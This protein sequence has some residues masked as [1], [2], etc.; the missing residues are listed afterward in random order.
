[1]LRASSLCRM[2]HNLYPRH[3]R[4]EEVDAHLYI[5]ESS[6][7]DIARTASLGQQEQPL[8]RQ[9]YLPHTI[10]GFN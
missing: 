9:S 10:V 3:A 4:G 8:L 6:N 7:W 5:P 2:G 1:M